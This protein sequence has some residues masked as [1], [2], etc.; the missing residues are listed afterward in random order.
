MGNASMDFES[1]YEWVRGSD[2]KKKPHLLLGNGFSVAYNA[3]IFSYNALLDH[4]QKQPNFSALS[5]KFFDR[6]NTT[7][8]ELVIRQFS[9]AAAALEILDGEKH[10]VEINRLK[11]EAEALK[12]L[13]AQAL[14][15]L[16]PE[17]PWDIADDTYVRVREFINRHH[18][19]YTANYDL[20][21]YWTLMQED[22]R[23][24]F[25]PSDDG[26][27]SPEHEADY[28]VWDHLSPHKQRL[29][30]LHGALHL[31]RDA[32]NAELQ[33]LTWI[34]TQEALIEQIRRQLNNNRFPLIVAEGTSK[35]KLTKIQTSDYLSKGLRS[36]AAIGGGVI[37]YGL[38]FSQNDAHISKA[39]VNSKVK[40]LAV[41]LYGD[42]KSASNTETIEAVNR[43]K[44]DR[45]TH[46]PSTPLD[47]K[48]FDA[49][50]IQL[51]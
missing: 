4:V 11:G 2:P 12:E 27:R 23:G 35:E 48:L 46:N 8:F 51:W 34:R 40:R 28:V 17:R 43:I 30:Y 33:K 39:L 6:L 38:S 7:D 22:K 13:L 1:A 32:E 31:Y 18:K 49:Q 36:L 10:K 42:T 14:A 37:A 45:S 25:Q 50:S 15:S 21:L 47:I 19:L 3:N 29:F 26:F 9:E 20:L 41:S 5:D 16:H 44:A 24:K